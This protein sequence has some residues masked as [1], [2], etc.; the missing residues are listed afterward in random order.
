[1]DWRDQMIAD[2]GRGIGFEEL[3][4]SGSGVIKLEFER[5]GD[6]YI[7]ARE[8]GVLFYLIR[9]IS[10][11]DRLEVLTAAL[12]CCHYSQSIR[13]PLLSGIQGDD[14]MFLCSFLVNES[15]SR[16]NIEGVIKMLG[17]QFDNISSM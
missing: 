17:E 1:M 7:E 3:D 4:F 16:P 9:R 6:V 8:D 5:R 10:S 12:K 11:H 14:D 13:F 2:V 15:F